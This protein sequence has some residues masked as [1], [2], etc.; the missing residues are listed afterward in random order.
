[1]MSEAFN[2]IIL[3]LASV[4]DFIWSIFGELLSMILETP[5][6]AFPVV[7][8]ILCGSILLVVKLIRK[9]GVKGKH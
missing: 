4:G 9:F 6:I 8:S 7:L 5:L 2:N 1:M 3:G